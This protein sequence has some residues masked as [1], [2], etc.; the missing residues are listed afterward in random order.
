[1]P[2]RIA[3]PCLVAA[4]GLIAL[5]AAPARAAE[6]PAFILV[7]L[8]GKTFFAPEGDRNGPNGSDAV[9]ILDVSDEARPKLAHTLALDNSVYGPPTNL[10]ITPDGRLGLVA[11]SVLMKQEGEAWYARA[12]E[13]LHVIDL[14]ASPPRLVETVTVGRQPS[15]LAINRAGDLALVANR[16]GKSVTVLGIAGTTVRTIGT[17]AVGDDAAAVAISPDGRRAF[18]SK[19]KAGRIGVL[20]IDGTSVTYDPALDMPVGAGVY[21]IEVTPDGTL[22]LTGNTGASP[23]DGHADSASVIRAEGERPRVIDW[24]GT[25]DTPEALTIAP[26]GRHAAVSVVRGA[27][28]PQKSPA[29]TPT[30]LAVLLAIEPGGKVR[31]AGQAEAGAVTQGIIFSPSGRYVYIGNYND[32]NLQVYRVEGD[33]IIDTGV[34]V[35]LPGQPASLRGRAGG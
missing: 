3:V 5:A 35:D 7:G 33:A 14:T 10:G 1:M 30:G 31:Y 26:D 24:V 29:F 11:S 25:G 28:A 17:V 6:A 9:A 20:T 4:L 16:E 19:N 15:G 32:R 13:R 34:K 23:S 18:F 27:A 22:A 8:D 12:D 2:V 21:G